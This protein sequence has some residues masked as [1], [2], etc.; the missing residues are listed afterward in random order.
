MPP[1]NAPFAHAFGACRGDIVEADDIEHGRAGEARNTGHGEGPQR[2]CWQH[3]MAQG[4]TPANGEPA[5]A[6][7]KEQ[8]EH[9]A[10]P[11]RGCC[12]PNRATDMTTWSARLL[13]L[14][15]VRIPRGTATTIAITNAAQAS[16]CVA[17]RWAR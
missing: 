11:E 17:R 2:D 6:Q 5:Q 3:E 7:A 8:N 14:R 1:D 15:A 4:A 13:G 12:C 10:D 9:N 16:S